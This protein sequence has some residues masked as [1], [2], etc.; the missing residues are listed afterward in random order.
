MRQE[1]QLLLDELQE[2]IEGSPGIVVT[3]FD[4]LNSKAT[5]Q[6]R[7]SIKGTGG[8]CEVVKKSLLVKAVN[9]ADLGM[10]ENILDGHIAIMLSGDDPI[11]TTKAV[12]QF[13]KENKDNLSIQGG[14]VEKVFYSAADMEKLSKLPGQNEMRAQ[15]VGLLQ[16]PLSKFLAVQHA[17]MTSV[18]H[19]LKNK[20]KADSEA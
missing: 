13:A 19:C 16:A 2:K 3:K 11:E 1:K 8:D 14:F 6:L 12:F 7:R 4:K 10:E 20:A 5:Q 9:A 15:F 18:I 17:V